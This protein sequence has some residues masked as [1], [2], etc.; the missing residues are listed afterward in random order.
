MKQTNTEFDSKNPTFN[1]LEDAQARYLASDTRGVYKPANLQGG[2]RPMERGRTAVW[3]ARLVLLVMINLAQL[4]ILS[5]TVEA[6]LAREFK[7][8][9]PLVLSSAACWV[10]ALT[11]FLWWKPTSR[12]HS[13][14]GY[15]RGK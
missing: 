13:S 9:L 14:T 3:Q 10:I 15:M 7:Q 6:A 1:L 11:I 12:R 8:L 4:W 2:K 5:A